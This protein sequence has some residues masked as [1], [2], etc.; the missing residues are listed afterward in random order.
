[1]PDIVRFTTGPSLRWKSARKLSTWNS[2]ALVL[3]PIWKTKLLKMFWEWAIGVNQNGNRWE[4]AGIRPEHLESFEPD[5][6]LAH[7]GRFVSPVFEIDIV[8]VTHSARQFLTIQTREFADTPLVCKKNGPDGAKNE[9]LVC[10]GI[11]VRLP[12]PHRPRV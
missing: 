10:G 4:L 7:L 8:T 3:G 12:T 2:K 11:Y 5:D 9:G 6:V 1:L